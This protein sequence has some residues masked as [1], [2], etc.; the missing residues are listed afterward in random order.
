MG[1][2]YRCSRLTSGNHFSPDTISVQADGVHYERRRAFGSSQE[3]V[4]YR[5]IAS[6]RLRSGMLFASIEIETAGGSQPITMHGLWKAD[7]KAV[8]AAIQQMQEKLGPSR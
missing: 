7:A 4:S 2:Q 8:L 6:V 5:Q 3:V 1:E